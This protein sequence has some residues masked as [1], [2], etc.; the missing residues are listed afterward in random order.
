[1][2]NSNMQNFSHPQQV[3]HFQTGVEW[4]GEMCVFNGKLAMSRK[5]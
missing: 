1:M 2:L 3:K 5:W 4:R